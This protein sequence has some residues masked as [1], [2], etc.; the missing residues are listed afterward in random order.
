MER[1]EKEG[2]RIQER[3]IGREGWNRMLCRD[4]CMGGRC[5]EKIDGRGRMEERGV[6]REKRE[7]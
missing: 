5:R 4:G 1:G 2:V 7:R 3:E 6:G